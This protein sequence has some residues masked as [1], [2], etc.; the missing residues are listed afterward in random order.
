MEIKGKL[1][2]FVKARLLKD[3]TNKKYFVGSI[4]EGV[5]L[6]GEE[7]CSSY[8]NA[9]FDVRLTGKYNSP[10]VVG[11]MKV[12]YCYQLDVSEGFIGVDCYKDKAGNDRTK[13]VLV[14]LNAKCLK[15]TECKVPENKLPF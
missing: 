2:V 6:E 13:A 9:N 10:E 11:A 8:K 1:N 7:K 12:G 15:E 4:S 14:I 5:K 3:G